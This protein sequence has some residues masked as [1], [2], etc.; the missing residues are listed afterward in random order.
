MLDDCAVGTEIVAVAFEEEADFMT[1][2]GGFRVLVVEGR[3]SAW[4][5]SGCEGE[6]GALI[7]YLSPKLHLRSGKCRMS[8]V[9]L[10]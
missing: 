8:I 3:L 10:E 7:V 9:T 4:A 5:G 2:A 1:A 6:D